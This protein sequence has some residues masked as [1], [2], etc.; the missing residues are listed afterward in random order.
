MSFRR[1]RRY[2]LL[3]L[4]CLLFV[5]GCGYRFAGTAENRIATGQSIWVAFIVNETISP[6]AQTVLRRALYEESHAMR[7]LYPADREAAADLRVRGKL[8]SYTLKAASYSAIDQVKEYRL[9]ISVDLELYRKGET[10]PVWKGPLLASQDFPASTNLALQH[11]AEEAA[12][13][14]A[15]QILARKFLVSVEQAY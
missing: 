10:A 9:L 8:T 2:P 3:V 6:T 7:G 5:A 12:L 4:C 14:A 15:S 11:N 13:K 1:F